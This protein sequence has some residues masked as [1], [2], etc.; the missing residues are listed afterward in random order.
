[1]T[2][3]GC[4]FGFLVLAESCQETDDLPVRTLTD[5]DLVEITL[6]AFSAYDD[7]SVAL[8]SLAAHWSSAAIAARLKIALAQG[9]P[10]L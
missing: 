1:V 9:V 6:T 5:I 2:S 7:T 3:R 8:R 4:S 10:G